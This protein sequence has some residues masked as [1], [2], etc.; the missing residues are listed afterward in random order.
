LEHRIR[1]YRFLRGDI[2]HAKATSVHDFILKYDGDREAGNHTF[3]NLIFTEFLSFP[4]R[5][6]HLLRRRLRSPRLRV[7]L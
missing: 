6:V 2:P 3:F 5:L 1:V 7:Q 4:H